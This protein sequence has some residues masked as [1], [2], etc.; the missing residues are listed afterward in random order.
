MEVQ[1]VHIPD[2]AHYR[3]LKE[4]IAANRDMPGPLIQEIGRAHV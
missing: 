3:E 4:F 1:A 2:N